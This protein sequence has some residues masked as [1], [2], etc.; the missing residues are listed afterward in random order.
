MDKEEIGDPQFSFRVRRF[1]AILLFFLFSS[2][3]LMGRRIVTGMQ[4]LP[5]TI[6][7]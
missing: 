7:N 2:E 1:Y 6:Y 4:M 5:A 3:C